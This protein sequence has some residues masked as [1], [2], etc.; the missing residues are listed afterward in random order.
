MPFEPYAV[1]YSSTELGIILVSSN[2]ELIG[3]EF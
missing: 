2:Y 1:S 3:F